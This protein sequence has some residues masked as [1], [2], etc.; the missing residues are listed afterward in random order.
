MTRVARYCLHCHFELLI[1]ETRLKSEDEAAFLLVAKNARDRLEQLP[2]AQIIVSDQLPDGSLPNLK[3]LV[4]QPDTFTVMVSQFNGTSVLKP[5]QYDCSRLGIGGGLT[6][7]FRAGREPRPVFFCTV[8]QTPITATFVLPDQEILDHETGDTSERTGKE[9]YDVNS[10][11]SRLGIR[12]SDNFLGGAQA[13]LVLRCVNPARLL[14]MFIQAK[15]QS[16]DPD[17][18][19]KLGLPLNA[20]DRTTLRGLGREP[21]PDYKTAAAGGAKGILTYSLAVVGRLLWG[22]DTQPRT[23]EPVALTVWDVYRAVRMEFAAAIGQ[24]VR[25]EP[26]AHLFDAVEVRDRIAEDIQKIMSQSFDMYGI[27][28]DRVS[29]FRFI[30]PKYEEVLERRANIARDSQQLG[31]L[32]K[33]AEI[34]RKQRAIDLA[35]HVDG[36]K[37]E[38]ELGKQETSHRADL[39]RHGIQEN[40]ETERERGEFLAEEQARE[41]ARDTTAHRH[42]LGK[43]LEEQ[44]QRLQLEAD[45]EKL[46]LQLQDEKM[47]MALGWQERMLRLQNEQQDAA[48]SRRIKL[49]EQYARLPKDSILTIALAENPQLAAAYAASVQAQSQ[50]EKVQM[51]EKFRGELATAYAGNNA[52]FTQLLQEAVRQWGQYQVAKQIGHKPPQ[53]VINVGLPEPPGA[54]S[55]DRGETPPGA[56]P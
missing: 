9:V 17:E 20:E 51:Q 37:T 34:A 27:Q 25:N 15:L 30:C 24:S 29:A 44:R 55:S 3:R 14:E 32:E 38:T 16:L 23:T 40:R 42:R 41:L 28:I 1:Q 6:A 56:T 11:V 8:S 2:L 46:R 5:G 49:L 31:D 7:G 35:D 36:S 45:Q 26:I 43:E 52:Q 54:P 53:Q 33:Q 47:K 19:V 22:G 50:Q 39:E 18:K 12:T 21:G 10:A 13:Q 4:V 48:V